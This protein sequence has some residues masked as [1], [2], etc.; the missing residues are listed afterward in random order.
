MRN[1][2]KSPQTMSFGV[3]PNLAEDNLKLVQ[4]FNSRK[5]VYTGN[6]TGK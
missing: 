2:R 1:L 4:E 3:N 5:L 6:D